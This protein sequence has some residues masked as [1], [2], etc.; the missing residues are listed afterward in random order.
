M[1]RF[2]TALL[3]GPFLAALFSA[4]LWAADNIQL[5]S[6][7]GGDLLAA[8]DDGVAKHQQMKVE[9]GADN[10]QTPVSAANPL[11]VESGGRAAVGAAVSGNPVLIGCEARDTQPAAVDDGDVQLIQCD[12]RGR[13]I[14]SPHCPRVLIAHNRIALTTTTETTLIATG[15]SG[16]FRDLFFLVASN[17]GTS[18]VR[19]DIADST[20]GTDRLSLDL[21]ANGGGAV[22]NMVVP[23]TQ[24]TA[25]NNWTA[26]LSAAV[27]TVYLTAIACNHN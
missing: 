13:V 18:E 26:T 16:I 22:L 8:D 15:G 3:A 4:P 10:T 11:P 5:N 6:G 27:S 21:A 19:V 24:G 9:F 2:L 7:T 20:G 12:D 17:E 1:K 23:L 25:N 14:T